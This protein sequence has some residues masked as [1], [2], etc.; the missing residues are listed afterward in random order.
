VVDSVGSQ[1]GSV[2]VSD[3]FVDPHAGPAYGQQLPAPL[4][5]LDERDRSVGDAGPHQAKTHAAD[6]AEQIQ[7]VHD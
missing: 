3:I 5:A 6:P 4:V 1:P 7:H 2:K